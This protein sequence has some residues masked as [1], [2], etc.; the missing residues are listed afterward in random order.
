MQTEVLKV[1]GG[2]YTMYR[3]KL[4]DGSSTVTDLMTLMVMAD[5]GLV[6]RDELDKK[7]MPILPKEEKR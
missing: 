7:G 5:H 4:V 3:V 6:H 1:K 2:T